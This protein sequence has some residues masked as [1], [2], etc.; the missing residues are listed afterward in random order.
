MSGT[1]PSTSEKIPVIFN[2]T[3]GGGRARR[4]RQDLER[5]V[6]DRDIELDW[7]A[8]NR[9]AHATELAAAAAAEGQPLVFAFGGDGTYN[10]VACGLLGS[11]TAMGVLPAGTTSVLAYELAIPRPVERALEALLLGDDRRI[12][13][14]STDRGDIFLLMLSAGPDSMVLERLGPWFKR[15]GGRLGVAAQALRELT[16]LQ[17]LPRLALTTDGRRIE[18][19]WVIL[20]N[21]RCF[22]G[23][24]H[25]TPGADLFADSLEAVVLRRSG[26]L[27]TLPF[28]FDLA[29]GCHQNRADV[30]RL[31]VDS[32]RLEAVTPTPLSYQIDGDVAGTLPVDIRVHPQT[33]TLRLPATVPDLRS[34]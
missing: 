8:T 20:G 1:K 24:Y 13:V 9:P 28:L 2:P 18:G 32:V 27:T 14:G 12:H 19:G 33:V 29:R 10:E 34:L 31:A 3:A 16:R 25:A 21:G 22:A 30:E 15:L 6:A 7:W 26:R 17:R 4:R 5:Y 23:P 11:D